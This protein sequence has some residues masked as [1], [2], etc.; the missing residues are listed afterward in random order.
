MELS[1][2]E[3]IVWSK[4]KVIIADNA[5]NRSM[6]AWSLKSLKAIVP[7][8]SGLPFL[9]DH[10]W[11]CLSICGII[12]SVN[13]ELKQPTFHVGHEGTKKANEIAFDLAGGYYQAIATVSIPRLDDLKPLL[14]RLDAKLINF[15]SVGGFDFETWYCPLCGI[16]FAHPKCPHIPP[17]K[18][19]QVSTANYAPFALREGLYDLGETS[20]VAV[21]R[22]KS[23]RRI[24]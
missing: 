21:P 1:N 4:E 3:K 7:L 24:K 23:A 6:T 16:P 12:D 11:K 13:I 2:K 22:L 9:L 8:A 17:A 19:W 5:V 15:L 18:P 14:D 20:F 10:D